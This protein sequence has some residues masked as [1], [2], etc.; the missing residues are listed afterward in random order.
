MMMSGG[1]PAAAGKSCAVDSTV[2]IDESDVTED[3][4]QSIRDVDNAYGT[5]TG[6]RFPVTTGFT[7]CS[8]TTQIYKIGSPTGTMYMQILGDTGTEPDEGN[9]IVIS[10]GVAVSGIVDGAMQAFSF[11]AAP[12]SLSDSTT[13][14]YI[15][16]ATGA[17]PTWGTSNRCRLEYDSA[18][19]VSIGSLV[20][21]TDK[22]AW[23]VFASG[24]DAKW[25]LS[26]YIP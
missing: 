18:G 26:G 14:T 10:G 25:T 16:Y 20:T 23:T 13:Y 12:P 3:T 9:S 22:A 19:G 15:L 21:S 5:W 2:Q 11:T 7:L 24:V 4:L 1:T 8:A 17:S 6:Q